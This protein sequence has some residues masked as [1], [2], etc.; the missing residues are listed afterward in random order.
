MRRSIAV[1][2][3]CTTAV[4]VGA[5]VVAA[6]AGVGRDRTLAARPKAKSIAELVARYDSRSCIEC[7]QDVHDQWANSIHSRSI[8]GT[9]R[10]AATFKTTVVNGLMEWRASGVGSP[11]DV[12]VE[13][14]MGCAKCHLP[15]LAD[16]TDAVAQEILATIDRW[17]AA[18]EDEDDDAADAAEA[19]LTSLNI[20]CLVCH[21]RN[22][23][24]HKWTDGYPHPGTVYGSRDGEH[25]D[26]KFPRIGKSPIMSESVLCGQCH[27]LGPNLELENPT[28]CATA[29][30]SY[31]FA[32]V[33]EGGRQTCQ[34]CHMRESGLGHDIQSY[35]A[36]DFAR[37]GV[38]MRVEAS[39][40]FWRDNATMRPKAKVRVELTNRTGHGVPDG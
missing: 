5:T 12:K 2:L 19:T 32:Y 18:I 23:I 39:P 40:V 16:A 33:P 13:H 9:G 28:Q 26:P 11:K 36:P 27:G 7:H 8:F 24:V 37:R 17:Q 4:V 34:D 38:E 31:L 29:Y 14:L 22:A 15:Q 1:A 21:N 25:P 10:T 30:G 35:R 6:P 20:N 3:A